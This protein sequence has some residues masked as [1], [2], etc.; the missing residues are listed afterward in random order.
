MGSA[1]NCSCQP[2]YI[3]Y[4]RLSR[5]KAKQLSETTNVSMRLPTRLVE[6]IDQ[7]AV[8]AGVS[9]TEYVLS[10]LPEHY[11]SNAETPQRSTADNDR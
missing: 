11:D 10:Y 1:V 4:K 5:L 6:R 3:A 7:S 8:Q 9:R 2:D